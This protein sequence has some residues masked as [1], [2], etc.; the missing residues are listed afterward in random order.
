MTPNSSID[1]TVT[2]NNGS[3]HINASSVISADS[4][5]ASSVSLDEEDE[6]P[7]KV[8]KKDDNHVS[9]AWLYSFKIHTDLSIFLCAEYQKGDLRRTKRLILQ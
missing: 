6:S 4:S 2:T 8:K 3:N 5:V 1:A 9:S 7:A